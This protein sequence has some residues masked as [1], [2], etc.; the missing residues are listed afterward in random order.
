MKI[1]DD[2]LRNGSRHLS[3]LVFAVLRSSVLLL[4][5]GPRVVIAPPLLAALPERKEEESEAEDT[6]SEKYPE[7][8]GRHEVT[9]A[10]R[11]VQLRIHIF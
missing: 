3:L 11:V 2:L 8:S 5:S 9:S 10:G 4:F 6:E 7:E 1:V